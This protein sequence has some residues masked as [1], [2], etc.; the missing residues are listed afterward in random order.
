MVN[1]LSQLVSKNDVNF[2]YECSINDKDMVCF[3]HEITTINGFSKDTIAYI[4][5]EFPKLRTF[6]ESDL[7]KYESD[8][9]II[10][11]NPDYYRIYSKNGDNKILL[12]KIFLSETY[13]ILK[14][15]WIDD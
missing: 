14:K 4:E 3:S 12:P 2:K 1:V 13:Q 5:L 6:M 15:M 9:F 10:L 7:K 8:K 11:D